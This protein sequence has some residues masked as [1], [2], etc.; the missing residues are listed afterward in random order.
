V[1]TSSFAEPIRTLADAVIAGI[2]A[3]E[4]VERPA[5]IVKELIENALDAGARRVTV[6]YDDGA[7][8]TPRISVD[9]DGAGIPADQLE[10]AV[11][12]HATSKI[13]ALD[14]LFTVGTFGF[15]GEALSSIAGVSRFELVSR[16]AAAATGARIVVA[17]G[18]VELREAAAARTG[19]RVVIDELF[20][21][22]PA[23]RKF[24][25]SPSAEY[26]LASDVVRRFALARPDVHFRVER[27]GR[28][29]L[30][31]AGVAD[32]AARLRQVYGADIA[33]GML[34]LEARFRGMAVRGSVS[35]AGIS[36]GSARRISAF[37]NGRY[38]NDRFLFR[39]VMEAYR[40]YLLKGRYP[41]A[42]I[43][44]EVDPRAVDVNVHPQKL[45]V[46]FAAPADVSGFLVEAI[47]DAL[48][49]APGPLGRWG[50]SNA[51]LR[52]ARHPAG[53]AADFAARIRTSARAHGAGARGRSG[54]GAASAAAAHAASGHAI[55]P[56]GYEPAS[57]AALAALAA[58]PRVAEQAELFAAASDTALDLDVVGQV[59]AG[60]IVCQ[61]GDEMLLVD[62]HAAHE[63]VLFERLMKSAAERA[64]VRQGLVVPV[65]ARVGGAG[66]DAVVRA[67]AALAEAG[68]ELEP[69]GEEDVVVRAVPALCAGADVA[70]L[71]ER[72]VADLV[73]TDESVAAA[74]IVEQIMATVACHSAVRVGKRLDARGARALLAEIGTVDFAAT[75]PH[76]R[77]VAR[78]LERTRIER[79]FGR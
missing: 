27:G 62:Q 75:C 69:F 12:R 53:E 73:R 40:T 57:A 61:R 4:V 2:A 37:V 23:R 32:P 34:A 5:S 11:A 10:L 18:R 41:A 6:A 39:A 79:L 56:P 58:E 52:T 47:R 30:E 59:F 31:H 1:Q 24:L 17:H 33:V 71:A 70:A 36:Y 22:V 74:R 19:T 45:E 42:A 76:G 3:G 20:A 64:V 50:L 68:W 28:A 51:E 77:P 60:Y 21:A 43:F 66:V 14:D 13:R 26:A 72:M 46:R 35:P 48:R 65:T 8:G 55:E 15:R 49:G 25:K 63:R 67:A 16:T 54:R 44:L 7:A 29:A 78:I 38:V 9:D